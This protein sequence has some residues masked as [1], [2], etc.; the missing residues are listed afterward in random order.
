MIS[1]QQ[2]LEFQNNYGYKIPS[3]YQDFLKQ[4]DGYIF[5]NGIRLYELSD[6][7]E[8]N[9]SLQVS[10]YQPEYLAIGDY[11]G[12]L[13]FLIKQ[14]IDAKEVF[15]V[16]ICDYALETAFYKINEFKSWFEKGCIIPQEHENASF[17]KSKN[18]T[19]YMIKLPANGIK[20]IAK[21]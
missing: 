7:K 19:L 18:G 1:E 21:I 15:V 8:M 11:S 5:E 6:L 20:D 14:K 16:D 10:M 2:I 9:E 12:G 4:Q 17:S 3:Q 13:I